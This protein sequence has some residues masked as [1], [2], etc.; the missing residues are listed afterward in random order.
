M[1]QQVQGELVDVCWGC[2]DWLNKLCLLVF[3]EF[4]LDLSV[5][6]PHE[7]S[8]LTCVTH[9]V[10]IKVAGIPSWRIGENSASL[11]RVCLSDPSE[12]RLQSGG[13]RAARS[14]P[15]TARVPA[16]RRSV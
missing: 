13:E 4:T 15:G 2:S 9:S 3:R 16:V 8:S 1:T 12:N 5:E 14:D 11:T 6:M 7:I 10:K